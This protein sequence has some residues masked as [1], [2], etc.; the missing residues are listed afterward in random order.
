ML[1]GQEND[2]MGIEGLLESKRRGGC[3][4]RL[5]YVWIM[6]PVDS[7]TFDSRYK[8]C[9]CGCGARRVGKSGC[10][11]DRTSLIWLRHKFQI[12]CTYQNPFPAC[13]L[14]ASCGRY[15]VRS[16]R[17]NLQNVIARAPSYHRCERLTF[18][19][20]N[21]CLSRRYVHVLRL[22]GPIHVRIIACR[23]ASCSKPVHMT[24][25]SLVS[26]SRIY[27]NQAETWAN[28]RGSEADIFCFVVEDWSAQPAFFN[29]SR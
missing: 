1:T 4:W 21:I 18:L 28:V 17:A 2:D 11:D 15:G 14:M 16:A 23:M 7:T 3:I 26:A 29:C 9:C 19:I 27:F 22:R 12:V 10:T 8:A 25:I 13:E 24:R 5:E 20:P 6:Y